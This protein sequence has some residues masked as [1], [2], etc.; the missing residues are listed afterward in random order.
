MMGEGE[1]S[2]E[3]AGPS[4]GAALVTG[5]PYAGA[6]RFKAAEIAPGYYDACVLLR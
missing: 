6:N 4:R 5:I 1:N 3:D 2:S